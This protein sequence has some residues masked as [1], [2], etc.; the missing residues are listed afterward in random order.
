MTNS[1]AVIFVTNSSLSTSTCCNN[2]SNKV[3][4]I[5]AVGKLIIKHISFKELEG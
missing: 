2:D 5:F 1:V 3:N 4:C